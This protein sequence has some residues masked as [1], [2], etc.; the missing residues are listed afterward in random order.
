MTVSL[1][2]KAA[3][4]LR[5]GDETPEYEVI[6]N[7]V[8]TNGVTEVL[9]HFYADDRFGVRWFDDPQLPVAIVNRED[10]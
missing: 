4:D 2:T 1:G 7:A 3:I 5:R 10:S 9:V 8:E 6:T